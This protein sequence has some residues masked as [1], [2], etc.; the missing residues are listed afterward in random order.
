M[1][2]EKA[3]IE[4]GAAADAFSVTPSV[5]GVGLVFA[6]PEILIHKDTDEME[7]IS[8]V[9]KES[10][11]GVTHQRNVL[12]V[13]P[14][15]CVVT[16]YIYGK[17]EHTVARSFTFP[18]GG[19]SSD[20]RGAQA[21]TA[22]NRHLRVQAIDSALLV[23]P[24]TSTPTIE[25]SSKSKLPAPFTTAF[26]QWNG[27]A[28]PI[29]TTVKANNPMVVKLR[30]AFPNGRVDDLA[31]AWESRLLHVNEQAFH[32]WAAI[33]RKTPAGSKSIELN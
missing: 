29:I 9:W 2:P 22:S 10:T 27:T 1:Q 24:S 33:V 3:F 28:A 21:E 17:G 25:F 20:P 11:D 13:K 15:Y 16:D 4:T 31:L 6:R 18:G 7:F 5:E 32:G 14:D 8:A 30:V 19:V 23:M 12:L 26:V